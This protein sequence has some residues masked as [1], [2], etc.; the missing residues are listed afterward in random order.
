MHQY[1]N[2]KDY[3]ALAHRGGSLETHE[4]TLEGFSYAV[5]IGCDYIETDV[6]ASKD[7]IPYIFHDDDLKRVA[8]IDKKFNDLNSYEIDKIRIFDDCKIPR[9]IDCLDAFSDIKFN[10]DLK[11]DEVMIPA[12][13]VLSEQKTYDRVC[14]ASFSDRRLVY[15]R[16]HYPKFCTSMGPNEIFK[17]KLM[18]LGLDVFNLSLIHI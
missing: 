10:I 14:I 8:G 17:I 6:Q 13:K 5:K 4:N 9:L 2:H 12:L 3:I 15:T 18:S 1:L 11:T 7:E 16:Q